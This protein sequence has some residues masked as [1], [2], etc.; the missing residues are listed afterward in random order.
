MTSN[1]PSGAEAGGQ[2]PRVLLLADDPL[3]ATLF[4]PEAVARLEAVADWDRYAGSEET[5]ELSSYVA[6]ADVL[7]TTW[8]SPFLQSRLLESTPVRL[9]AHCGGEIGTRM[10]TAARVEQPWVQQTFVGAAPPD[11][12]L[13]Q[14]GIVIVL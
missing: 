2:R 3:F 5:P 4:V 1:R 11:A 7:V 9:I 14:E 13:D 8:H 12:P 10:E 6:R